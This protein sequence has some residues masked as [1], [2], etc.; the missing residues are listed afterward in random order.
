M[1]KKI[2]IVAF[3]TVRYEPRVRRQI[4]ALAANYDITL[5]CNDNQGYENLSWIKVEKLNSTFLRNLTFIWHIFNQNYEYAY[6]SII[7]P[8]EIKNLLGKIE[9]NF[10]LILTHDYY[11]LPFSVHLAEKIGAKLLYDAHEYAPRQY[12]NELNF[13]LFKK[14]FVTYICQKY[15]PK[16][17]AMITVGEAISRQYTEDTQVKSSI[18]TNAPAYQFLEARFLS[19]NDKIKLVHHGLAYKTR[20]LDNLITMLEVLESRFELHLYLVGDSAYIKRLKSVSMRDKRL[21][22][23]DPVQV[24]KISEELNKYDIGVIAWKPVTFNLKNAY[25]NKFFEFIQARLAI[26]LLGPYPDMAA[27]VSRFGNGVY[28]SDRYSPVELARKLNS[29]TPEQINLFKVASNIAAKELNSGENAKILR[30]VVE[31]L[32]S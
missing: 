32:V 26:A 7:K 4:D 22:I 9:K 28:C 19:K 6:N 24:E 27:S 1:K 5:C 8:E 20:G 31:N 18:V 11:T 17:D 15:I 14:S 10:D 23:H 13:V 2:L 21:F 16:V 29:L 30:E 12:E 3:S 25:P